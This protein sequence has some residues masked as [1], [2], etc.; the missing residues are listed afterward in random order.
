MNEMKYRKLGRNG[1]LV[2]AV[3]L[4]CMGMSYGYGPAGNKEEMIA[5]IRQAYERGVTFFDTAE[6]YQRR[7]GRTGARTHAG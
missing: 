5:L 4:G 1:P 6:V 2:S 7:V 3:G